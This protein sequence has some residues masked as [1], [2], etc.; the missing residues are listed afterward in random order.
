MT[1]SGGVN[2][3]IRIE[4]DPARMQ[5]LGITAVDVNQQLR[6]LNLD[7]PGGRAEIGGGEQSIRVLGGA[8]TAE[9]LSET[10]IL[11]PGGRI[12]RLSDLALVHDGIAEVRS[13]SRLN[14]RPTTIFGVFKAKGLLRH[15][16]GQEVEQELAKITEENPSVKMTKLHHRRLHAGDV[17][18]GDQRA[19]RGLH[20]GRHRGLVLPARLALDRD[21]GARDSVVGDS[22]S[23]G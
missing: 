12:A 21:L 17:R 2:R 11:L 14:G 3:E 10:R 22:R 20:P 8:R 23:C 9:Q 18:L 4:L 16:G 7:A 13:M 5:A 1:R 15:L 19:G 6:V